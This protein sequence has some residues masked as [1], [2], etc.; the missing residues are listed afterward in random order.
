MKR[1]VESVQSLPADTRHTAGC[2]VFLVVSEPAAW[3]LMGSVFSTVIVSLVAAVYG[4]FATTP[5]TTPA[6]SED[7]EG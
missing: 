6:S 7:T 4:G 2:V 1:V 5:A 3:L